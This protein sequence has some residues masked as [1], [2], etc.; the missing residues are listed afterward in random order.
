[1]TEQ[2][3][4]GSEIS[5]VWDSYVGDPTELRPL[6][7]QDK[8]AF[9]HAVLSK[10]GTPPQPTPSPATAAV[11][12][13]PLRDADAEHGQPLSVYA[14]TKE[15]GVRGVDAAAKALKHVQPF[16]QLCNLAPQISRALE[17]I[18]SLGADPASDIADGVRWR[19]MIQAGLDNDEEFTR[20]VLEETA[21]AKPKSLAEFRVVI[22]RAIECVGKARA[23]KATAPTPPLK[24]SQARRQTRRPSMPR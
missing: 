21:H 7:L 14:T 19:T 3:P 5:N 16:V 12:Y 15:P 2:K 20:A 6:T 1:M 18:R 13:G 10:W 17:T 9:A 8:V 4:T 23:A 11:H 24:P 22:D